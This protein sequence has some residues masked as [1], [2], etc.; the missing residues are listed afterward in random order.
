MLQQAGV[1]PDAPLPTQRA[2][3]ESLCAQ[4][5]ERLQQLDPI[6]LK[7]RDL[8]TL[9]E[10]LPRILGSVRRVGLLA[11][12]PIT[13]S[14][15]GWN[16]TSGAREAVR[17]LRPRWRKDPVWHRRLQRGVRIASALRGLAPLRWR[18]HDAW[19]H[20]HC[21]LPG[22]PLADLLPAQDPPDAT[23]LTW[24][25]ALALQQLAQLHRAGLTH[26]SID[27]QHLLLQPGG[28]AL[29]WLDVLRSVP[30][31]TQA[32]VSDLARCLGALDH[33]QQH[34]LTQLMA[35]WGENPPAT[36]T[37]GLA[38]LRRVLADLLMEE[39]HRIV[40]RVRFRGRQQRRAH[41]LR[42][43]RAL[44]R[45]LPPP[46]GH[47]CL[48][49]ALDGSLFLL[50]SDGCGVWCGTAAGLPAQHMLSLYTPKLGLKAQSARIML[51]AWARREDG[52]EERRARVQ[53]Q[54]GGSDAL[55][56]ALTRWLSAQSR[57]RVLMLL[58]ER[59]LDAQR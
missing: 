36:A 54:L 37:D 53:R 2:A 1:A 19:P 58:L 21:G 17:C 10:G 26:G 44:S 50:K 40:L 12:D 47:C 29:V 57:L 25:A 45:A 8:E 43:T 27:G 14:W 38:L 35:P 48:R 28:L 31:S 22:V 3:L 39:R 46:S 20:V 18:P 33:K 49:A 23:D 7:L 13:V 6:L 30:S 16:A 34:P 24:W 9:D 52:D 51:R 41:L 11:C 32:D 4:Q 42:T 55:A 59:G 56:A 5:P 15:W